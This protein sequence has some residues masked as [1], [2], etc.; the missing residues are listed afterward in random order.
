MP[1]AKGGYF[2]ADGLKVP[3]VTAVLETL[4]WGKE[5]LMYWAWDLGKQGFAY[6]DLRAQ[7]ATVGTI[8]HERIEFDLLGQPWTPKEEYDPRDIVASDEPFAEY[9]RWKGLHEIQVLLAEAPLVSER[10]KFA[11]TPDFLVLARPFGSDDPF[12][13]TLIDIK[14]SSSVY[15]SHVIQVAAYVALIE[16]VCQTITGICETGHSFVE[17]VVILQVSRTGDEFN[18]KAV[19]EDMI[20]RAWNLFLKLL[21]IHND[22]GFFADLCA[23]KKKPKKKSEAASEPD[24]EGG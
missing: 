20:D 6:K 1:T 10:L 15:E 22:K 12:R 13:L 23:R 4:G 8:V 14:T 2:T 19:P 21:A 18:A 3:S 7:A 24:A 5:A 9:L 11:G 16:E 17:D